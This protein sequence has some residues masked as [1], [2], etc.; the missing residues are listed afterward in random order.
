MLYIYV[1]I[2]ILHTIFRK[3]KVYALRT[4]RVDIYIT[5]DLQKDK[6][7]HIYICMLHTIFRKTKVHILREKKVF[8]KSCAIYTPVQYIHIYCTGFT[9]R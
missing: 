7:T 2:Y 5:Q 9:E 6:G 8:C 1:Y 3:I 4:T